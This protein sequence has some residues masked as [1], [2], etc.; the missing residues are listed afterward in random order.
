MKIMA[1]IIMV[2]I[3]VLL[4]RL[5]KMDWGQVNNVLLIVIFANMA[6]SDKG[7]YQ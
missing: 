3:S 4:V 6:F 2:I 5:L 1:E 7:E